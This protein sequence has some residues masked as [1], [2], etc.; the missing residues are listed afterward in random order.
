MNHFDR[1]QAFIEL[2]ESKASSI[3]SI[4][5]GFRTV[6]EE[7]GFRY[8]AC[9]SHVDPLDHPS[10]AAVLHNYPHAWVKRYSDAKLHRIDPVLQYAEAHQAPF[11]WDAAFSSH[12]ITEAQRK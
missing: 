2:C 10:H 12:P 8:F 11:F 9:C 7:L 4:T 6:L 5:A 1:V 3:E